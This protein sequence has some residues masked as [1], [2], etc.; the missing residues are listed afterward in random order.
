MV[1]LLNYSIIKTFYILRMILKAS[2]KGLRFTPTGFCVF[3]SYNALWWACLNENADIG[4]CL[5]VL[6]TQN[7]IWIYFVVIFVFFFVINTIFKAVVKYNAKWRPVGPICRRQRGIV[8]R[9]SFLKKILLSGN[10]CA[11]FLICIK[12]IHFCCS[13]VSF[14][15]C[16]YQ[17]RRYCYNSDNVIF[18]VIFP[19]WICWR[20]FNHSL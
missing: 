6:L 17:L 8:K 4:H 7:Y 12:W 9:C 2:P 10:T 15:F 13:C 19:G 3:V 20:S 1:S 16:D 5:S 11:L 18:S 14:V